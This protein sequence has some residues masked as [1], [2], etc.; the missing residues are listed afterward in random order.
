MRAKEKKALHSCSQCSVNFHFSFF[1][2]T[3]PSLIS[4]GGSKTQGVFHDSVLLSRNAV[5]I[6]WAKNSKKL[7]V[8]RHRPA[9][10]QQS[11]TSQVLCPSSAALATPRFFTCRF[12][13]SADFFSVLFRL[14]STELCC[15]GPLKGLS[16]KAK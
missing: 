13:S 16:R 1:E 9:A 2:R 14:N 4:G 8:N 11:H 5:Q 12:F 3:S 6:F 15:G 7:G 10:L